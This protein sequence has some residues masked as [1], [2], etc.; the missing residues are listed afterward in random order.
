M[1]NFRLTSIPGLTE[2]GRRKKEEGRRKREEGKRLKAEG[3]RQKAEDRRQ[4]E[5]KIL[6][7]IILLFGDRPRKLCLQ[8]DLLLLSPQSN[9]FIQ[10]GKNSTF[11]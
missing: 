11:G 9:L 4:K 3:G 1:G 8:E 6:K 2:E 5:S 10:K 7:A